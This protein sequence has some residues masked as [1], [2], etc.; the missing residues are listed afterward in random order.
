MINAAGAWVD[1]IAQLAGIAPLGF[2]P[3]RRSMVRIPAPGGHDVTKWPMLFGPGESWYAKPDA[4]KLLVSPAEEHATTPHDAWADDMVLAEGI[5]RYEAH[6]TEPV[7][8]VEHSW[9]GLRTF[10]P[11][12][13][14]VIGFAP[15]DR[16]FFWLAGQGGYGMQSSPAASQL[17]ADL[18]TG[19]T[20]QIDAQAVA[21]LDPARFV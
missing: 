16:G 4:G 2:T 17:A 20:P 13:S 14:L 10:S 5:A 7:T 19:Q 11:D 3:N 15:Q 18:I 12:R 9:A 6:V 21:A 1:E 8:R